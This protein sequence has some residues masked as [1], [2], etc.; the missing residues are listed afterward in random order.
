[1]EA[2]A[3][4]PRSPRRNW[5]GHRLSVRPAC[6]VVDRALHRRILSH[7]RHPPSHDGVPHDAARWRWAAS[8]EAEGQVVAATV[9]GT[10]HTEGR[11]HTAG[12]QNGAE[13]SEVLAGGKEGHCFPSPSHTVASGE[14]LAAQT[15]EP[16]N[17]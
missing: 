4:P 10:A 1:M 11:H 5:R 2:V 15:V 13:D 7:R 16:Y 12:F 14:F 6:A 9:E 8:V 17:A 3:V